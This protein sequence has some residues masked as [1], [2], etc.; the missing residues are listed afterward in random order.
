MNSEGEKE[1]ELIR[2]MALWNDEEAFR[3]LFYEESDAITHR[4]IRS[5][6]PFN[7][8]PECLFRYITTPDGRGKLDCPFTG[9]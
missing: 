7:Q 3:T 6:L 5:Q 2:R 8:R 4:I 9:T 1:A